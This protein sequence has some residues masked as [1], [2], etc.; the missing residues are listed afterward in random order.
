MLAVQALLQ[1][2]AA[3][4]FFVTPI[5]GFAWRLVFATHRAGHPKRKFVG[6]GFD[7]IVADLTMQRPL[8]GPK[9]LRMLR[10]LGLAKDG[11][12]QFVVWFSFAGFNTPGV[13]PVPLGLF[14]LDKLWKQRSTKKYASEIESRYCN[15]VLHSLA[16]QIVSL[17]HRLTVYWLLLSLD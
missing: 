17:Y 5:R 1:R 4:T 7:M 13:Y 14:S 15:S 2:N 12:N 16:Y 9:Q 10:I 11:L 8:S 3:K 6:E